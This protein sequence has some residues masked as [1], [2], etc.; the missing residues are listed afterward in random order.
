M[1]RDT[2]MQTIDDRSTPI[3][4]DAAPK[5]KSSITRDTRKLLI[6][7]LRR[8]FGF[9]RPRLFNRA[10]KTSDDVEM[11]SATEGRAKSDDRIEETAM[12]ECSIATICVEREWSI[13][14]EIIDIDKR[15]RHR[16]RRWLSAWSQTER[17]KW[18]DHPS[19]ELVKIRS[20]S[21]TTKS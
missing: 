8:L 7:Y 21:T 13:D 12:T 9:L 17:S 3:D 6:R 15:K 18:M 1:T 14:G 2:H 11:N 5:E 20:I 16:R 19:V 4:N 10:V